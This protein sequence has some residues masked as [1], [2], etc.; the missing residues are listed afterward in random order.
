MPSFS[1]KTAALAALSFCSLLATASP[2]KSLAQVTSR[3][4][5]QDVDKRQGS[6]YKNIVYFTNWGIYG[7]DY[8]PAQLPAS[9]IT[10]VLYS[11]ANLQADG[12]VYLSDTYADL[13]KHYPTDSWN[14]VGTNVYGCVKQ[15]FLL[16]KANRQLKVQLSIGGWTYSTNF[17]SAAST[18]A[19]RQRFASTAVR[20]LADLGFDGLDIDWEY[21]ASAQEGANYV[22][23]LQAVRSALDSYSAQYAGGYHFLLTVASPAG[24]VNYNNMQLS[25]MAGAIDW[26]NLMA[27]D[28]AGGWDTVAGHQANLHPNAGNPASTPFSTDRAVS[29]YLAAGVP[30]AKIV[31]GM[32]I[33]GRSFA[34]TS[35]LGQSFTG[36]G[37]GTW[38]NGVY[39]YKVLPQAGATVLY[40]DASG[41]T[42]SYSA[43]SRELVSYDTPDMVARKVAY[44]KGRGLGGSMFWEASAD[45]TDGGSLI[46]TS[47]SSLGGIDSSPNQ[48]S[49]P[50][51]KYANLVAGFA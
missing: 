49:F 12:T 33:Y 48:L 34:G 14:D 47:F 3:H 17:A 39:D 20:L 1:L 30:A 29:D 5:Q 28:Y 44:L 42:Y 36:V 32:P 10:H 4:E 7:R 23:L 31:L 24:P 6:G 38:E 22:L 9:K 51:S 43:S 13:D 19:N 40:D 16:K 45:R 46:A 15:L 50:N 11:F 35:G 27:Y 41:A 26:F 18:A 25:A 37:G 21:P 2:I 8:Q